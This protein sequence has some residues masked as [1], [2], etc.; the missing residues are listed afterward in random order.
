MVKE[1]QPALAGERKVAFR[2]YRDLEVWQKAIELIESV[3]RLTKELPPQERF[4]LTSQIQRAAVSIASN[5]A[6]GYGRTHRGDYLHH[7]SVARGSLME[8]ETCLVVAGRLKFVTRQQAL[9]TWR[10]SQQVG[11]ML[12]RLIVSLQSATRPMP[13]PKPETPDPKP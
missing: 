13:N 3:Y 4:G 12:G 10:L 5:I 11:K 1:Q 2:T 9:G 8:V 7:L 6:E